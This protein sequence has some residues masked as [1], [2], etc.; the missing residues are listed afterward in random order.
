MVTDQQRAGLT[1]VANQHNPL[2]VA[3]AQALLA[4][5]NIGHSSD[6]DT[7]RQDHLA[8]EQQLKDRSPI[9]T[10]NGPHHVDVLCA[11]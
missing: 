1:E 4:A 9:Q 5:I 6:Y 2:T 11:G 7:W 8:V 10:A 3:Q